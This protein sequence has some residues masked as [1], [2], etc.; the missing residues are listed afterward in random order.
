LLKMTV[1]SQKRREI[2]VV[3][4]ATAEEMRRR[5][6]HACIV[7]VFLRGLLSP[8]GT[9]S[10]TLPAADLTASS[11]GHAVQICLDMHADG[12]PALATAEAEGM[13]SQQPPG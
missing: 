12:T 2:A 6:P 8:P 10:E 5:F 9:A 1:W 13:R 3:G 4:K 7:A 11:L